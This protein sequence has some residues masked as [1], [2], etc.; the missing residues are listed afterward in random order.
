MERK[1]KLLVAGILAFAAIGSTGTVIRMGYIHTLHDRPDFL[2]ATTDVATWSTVEPGTGITAGSI[3]TLRPLV[4]HWL[5]RMGLAEA[6]RKGRTRNHSPSNSKGK[7]EDRRGYRRSLSPS[8]LVPTEIG[9]TMATQIRGAHGVDYA[10]IMY[11]PEF[12]VTDT[13]APCTPNG[14]I[15][16]TTTVRQEHDGPPRLQLRDSFRNSLYRFQS[17][18][19]PYTRLKSICTLTN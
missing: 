13:D 17:R 1:T 18:Q 16:Q 12:V 6:P 7:R 11:P 8:D 19:V 10:A 14:H 3:A 9:G 5:W 2:Y 15:M 4:R